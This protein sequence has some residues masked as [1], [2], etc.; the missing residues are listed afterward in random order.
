MYRIFCSVEDREMENTCDLL[1]ITYIRNLYKDNGLILHMRRW[2]A[3]LKRLTNS[4][5]LGRQLS[6]L[7][8]AQSYYSIITSTVTAVSVLSLAFHID[9][10][11]L[12]FIF[13]ALI[14]ATIVIGYFMDKHD[15]TA[16]DSLK[17][18]EMANRF[19]NTGDIKMQ[20]FQLLQTNILLEAL[21]TLQQNQ[22]INLGELQKKYEEY[23]KKWMAPEE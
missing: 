3:G 5:F 21:K 13:P 1:I 9:F 8:M 10:L 12:I 17:S 22:T 23:A 15:I 2:I 4:K 19:L 6:R 14:L 18:N 16:E 7:K 11:W 20:E